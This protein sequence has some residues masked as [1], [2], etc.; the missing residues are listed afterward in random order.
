[1]IQSRIYKYMAELWQQGIKFVHKLDERTHGWLGVVATAIKETLIPDTA[2]MASSISYIAL[3][4]LFPIILLSI[5]IASFSFGPSIDQHITIQQLEFVAPALSQL[6]GENIDEIVRARGPITTFALVSLIWSASTIFYTLTHSL[7]KIWNIRQRRSAW[8]VRGLAILVVLAF[9]GPT[10]FLVSFAGTVIA[11]LHLWLPEQILPIGNGISLI[12]TIL[13]D[14]SLF[15]MLY[16]LLPHGTST[17]REILP[18]AFGAGFLWE[19]AKNSFLSF[20][21]T[22]ISISNLV[23]G[24]VA[25][26]IAFLFWA[27]ISSLIFLFGAYLSVAYWNLKQEQKSV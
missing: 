2:M 9:V 17:W 27:Y 20:V 21:S 14:V 10:L 23:Y 13:L 8:K 19:L 11:N 12:L 4:T 15:M 18:G 5:S 3:F 1:M 25:T 22:Y 24:T 26:I 16:M 7:N 6:L